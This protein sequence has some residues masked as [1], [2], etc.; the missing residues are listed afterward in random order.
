M[1]SSN[2]LQTIMT[3]IPASV[4]KVVYKTS[5]IVA[6][7]LT[8]VLLILPSFQTVAGVMIPDSDR[9]I[10][11]ATGALALLAHLADSNTITDPLI[12]V[13]AAPETGNPIPPL[14]VVDPAALELDHEVE[15][16]VEKSPGSTDPNAVVTQPA[17]DYTPAPT[18]QDSK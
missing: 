3:A 12:D 18:I 7:V 6:A 16:P 14:G 13:N 17:P 8:L 15:I 2:A 5:K 9:W 4:R 1:D 11:I 10:A